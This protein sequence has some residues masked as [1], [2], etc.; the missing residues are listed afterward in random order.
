MKYLLVLLALILSPP[1]QAK[2]I[3]LAWDANLEAD[4]AGYKL[5]YWS[6]NVAI[7]IKDCGNVTLCTL[8]IQSNVAYS[9]A[10]T[11]YNTAGLSSDLSEIV[12]YWEMQGTP[13]SL[14]SASGGG[15]NLL[16]LQGP[17]FVKAYQVVSGRGTEGVVQWNTTNIVTGYTNSS[18]RVPTLQQ[19]TNYFRVR[20]IFAGDPDFTSD[21]SQTASIAPPRR[22]SLRIVP[23]SENILEEVTN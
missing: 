2:I 10:A 22:P 20:P 8:D 7:A 18:L 1:A 21:F 17:D 12:K 6:P 23:P 16:W 3:K 5:H 11:A 13:I 15:V 4:I 19:G 14:V 9:I